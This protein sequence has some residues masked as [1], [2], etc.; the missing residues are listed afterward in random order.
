MW[1]LQANVVLMARYHV[2]KCLILVCLCLQ[3]ADME[4]AGCRQI[5]NQEYTT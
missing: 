3:L 4:E 1:T 2:N 5:Q